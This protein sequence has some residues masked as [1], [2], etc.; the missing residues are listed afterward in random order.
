MLVI[1]GELP[2]CAYCTGE[3]KNTP[4]QKTFCNIFYL[5]YIYSRDIFCPFVAN[6]YPHIYQF[7]ILYLDNYQNGVVIKTE[8]KKQ[9]AQKNSYVAQWA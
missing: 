7:W 1:F 9:K 3:S 5:G 4:L 6:L 8:S 2:W